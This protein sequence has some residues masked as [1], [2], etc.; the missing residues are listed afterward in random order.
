[1]TLFSVPEVFD[2]VAAQ[3]QAD[4]E[5]TR[6]ALSHPGLKGTALEEAF[7]QF[8]RQHMPRSLDVSTGIL[9]DSHGRQSRQLDVIISDAIKTPILYQSGETRVIPAECAYAVIEVKA[10]LDADELQRCITNMLSVRQ[11]AKTAYFV[12]MSAMSVSHALYGRQWKV[13]P[14][15]YFVFAYDSI[16]LGR[17]RVDLDQLHRDADLP[18]WERIDTVCVLNQ[19]VICNRLSDGTFSALPADGSE[20]FV[21]RTRRALLLF[22]TLLSV[23]LFQ[24]TLPCFRFTDYL[25]QVRF[26]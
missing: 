1:M 15:S 4:L 19:G 26:D 25:G 24:A 13:W 7:R 21:N 6:A 14:T 9:V 18:P 17:L 3:M 10:T 8:L 11:L 12:P 22:Y 16:N 23:P 2:K 20:L 5:K